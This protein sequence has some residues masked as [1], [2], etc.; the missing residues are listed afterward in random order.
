MYFCAARE[1]RSGIDLDVGASGAWRQDAVGGGIRATRPHLTASMT[2]I[3]KLE[4][5]RHALLRL[6]KTLLDAQRVRYER[7]HGR[8]ESTGEL[9]DL[10]LKD[11]SF[12]WL[13]VLSALIAGL[14]EV[15]EAGGDA[16]VAPRDAGVAPRDA[17]VEIRSVI[18]K[19]RTLVRFEGNPGFTGPYREIIESVPDALVAHVQFSRLLADFGKAAEPPVD[20]PE[21][22]STPA[23][24]IGALSFAADKHR[25]QRRKDEEASPYINHPIAL[26]RILAVEGGVD[27]AVVLCAAVLHDTVEDTQTSYEELVAQFGRD[28]ADVVLEVTDDKALPKAERKRL[29]VEH[30]PRLSRAAKLVKLADKIANVRDVADHPPSEWPLERR[31]EYF[32]WAKRVVDGLRG[33]HAGLEAAFDAAWARRP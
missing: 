9:L 33:T 8:V 24:L 1:D 26:A 18:D 4:D 3:A 21:A 14:D 23:A 32:D 12:E 28:V 13:R 30:A 7:E 11:A 29:Q 6:H 19:L 27:D 10:V 20:K 16:G 5:L 22:A 2:A 15:T 31:R 25:N 17:G